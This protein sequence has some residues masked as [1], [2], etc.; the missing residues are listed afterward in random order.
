M[1]KMLALHRD[2]APLDY[3]QRVERAADGA[4]TTTWS[5][6]NALV[7]MSGAGVT[8]A[9][10]LARLCA[11]RGIDASEVVAFGDMPND[12]DMLRGSARRTRWRTGTAHA[13]DAAEHLAPRND[14]DGVAQVLESCSCS[15]ERP[16]AL[17]STATVRVQSSSLSALVPP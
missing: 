4:V 13:R 14:D 16:T 9:S 3:W 2:H 12:V 17:P 6:T 7:E 5:S 10:T 1:V 8:K 15:A 11:E